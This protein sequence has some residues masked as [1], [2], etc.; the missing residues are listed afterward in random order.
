MA[1]R[2]PMMG[3][4]L[5]MLMCTARAGVIMLSEILALQRG[6]E[7]R[8]RDGVVH[9]ARISVVVLHLRVDMNPRHHEHPQGHPQ[10]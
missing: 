9:M 7:D 1:Q 2:V 6:R 10:H 5:D 3:N 8:V 4:G